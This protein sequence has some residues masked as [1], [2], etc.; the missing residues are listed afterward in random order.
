MTILIACDL[1]AAD[2]AAV[3]IW[4]VGSWAAVQQ[5][6]CH[7]LTVTQLAFTPDGS[8][9]VSVS[10]DRSLAVWNRTEGQLC[11]RKDSL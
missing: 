10:R 7:T 8:R 3:W 11:S 2:V 5:L 4:R 6:E 1:Q 9:L